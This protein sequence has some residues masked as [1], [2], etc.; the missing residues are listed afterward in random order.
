VASKE[1]GTAGLRVSLG[2][3]LRDTGRLAVKAA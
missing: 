2:G 1:P 3:P